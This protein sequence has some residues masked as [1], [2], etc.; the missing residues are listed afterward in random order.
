M[1]KISWK[2]REEQ[3]E[4]DDEEIGQGKEGNEGRKYLRGKVVIDETGE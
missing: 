1:N 2:D 4:D 3:E